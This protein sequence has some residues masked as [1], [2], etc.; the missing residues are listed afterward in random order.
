MSLPGDQ[1]AGPHRTRQD[2]MDHEVEASAQ[3]VRDHLRRPLAGS[4]NLP[5]ET[6]GNTVHETAPRLRQRPSQACEARS[7]C[8]LSARSVVEP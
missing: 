7:R 2:T 8:Q 3:R 6:A 1:I 5:M 4:R